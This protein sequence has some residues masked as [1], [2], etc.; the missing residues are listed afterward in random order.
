M[1]YLYTLLVYSEGKW[2]LIKSIRH[3]GLK[4][5]FNSGGNDTRGIN[6][7]HE[8]N[9]RDQLAALDSTTDIA[10]M[11]LPGWRLHPLKGKD[12]GRHAIWVSGNW[13]MT[14]EFK[15]GDAYVVDYEDYH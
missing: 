14:F 3:K 7:D 6:S 2:G 8:G 5:F 10:D 1:Q 12:K 15:N 9:L 13:R 4:K 11:D